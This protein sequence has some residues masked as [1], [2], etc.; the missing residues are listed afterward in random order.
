VKDVKLDGVRP[1]PNGCGSQRRINVSYLAT[2]GKLAGPNCGWL[3]NP[4]KQAAV[5]VVTHSGESDDLA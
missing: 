2:V 5:A 4:T 1:R 3:L